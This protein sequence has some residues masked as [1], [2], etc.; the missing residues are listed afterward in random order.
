M[1]TLEHRQDNVIDIF[2]AGKVTGED[3][4]TLIPKLESEV[5]QQ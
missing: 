5:E 3:Y 1:H 2:L 4:E